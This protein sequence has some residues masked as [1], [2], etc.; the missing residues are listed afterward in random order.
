MNWTSAEFNVAM[1]RTVRGVRE[2]IVKPHVGVLPYQAA[3]LVDR[4]IKFTPAKTTGQQ[5]GA[6]VH[7]MLKIFKVM[8]Q[9]V[10]EAIRASK[11]PQGRIDGWVHDDKRGVHVRINCAGIIYNL[12]DAQRIHR[13]NYTARGRTKQLAEGFKFLIAPSGVGGG[14]GLTTYL[15]FLNMRAGKAKAGWLPAAQALGVTVDSTVSRHAPGKGLYMD[16]MANAR[17][18]IEV[19]NLT[20]WAQHREEGQRIVNGALRA[21]IRDMETHLRRASEGAAK[22]AGLTVIAA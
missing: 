13:A 15:E 18:S 3:K 10:I 14:F 16:G 5:Y 20:K 21:R 17:P 19:R 9:V 8:P 2:G 6:H 1:D 7:D 12:S 4:I 11:K 22:A